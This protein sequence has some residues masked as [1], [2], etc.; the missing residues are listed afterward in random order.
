MS[1][2][3]V[4]KTESPPTSETAFLA[5][6][7]NYIGASEVAAIMGLDPDKTPLQ[8]Y[9]EKVGLAEPFQGNRHTKR[10]KRLE[11]I[12]AE[13][14]TADQGIE[15][16]AEPTELAHPVYSFIRGHIDRRERPDGR[17]HEIKCPSLGMFSKVKREGLPVKWIVQLQMYMGMDRSTVGRWN[18]FCSDQWEALPFEVHAEPDLYRLATE[19]VNRF[20]NEHVLPRVPPKPAKADEE[21][22]KVEQ[23]GGEVIRRNDPEFVEAAQLLRHAIELRKDNEMLFE[24]AKQWLLSAID[25]KCG[26][27]EGGSVRLY[28]SE[29]NGKMSFDKKTLAACHPIDRAKIALWLLGQTEMLGKTTQELDA[30]L[31]E[32]ELDISDFEKRGAPFKV[33]RPYLIGGE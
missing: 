5:D 2:A 11:Q 15:L 31:K 10:G 25:E 27:Y 16:Y 24:M 1:T 29:Q 17:P 3:M 26:K 9:N 28:Y 32:C 19:K 18:V 6:R 12:A 21:L 7:P 8:V 30:V 33:F 20:W 14:F 13:E 4:P 22:I 23:V